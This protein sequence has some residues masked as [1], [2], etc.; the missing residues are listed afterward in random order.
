[1]KMSL[2]IIDKP[3]EIVCTLQFTMKLGDW[4][5][6]KETLESKEA[7]VELKI[8]REIRNLVSKLESTLYADCD[9]GE[10]T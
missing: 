1:M 10:R 4:K 9:D 2:A 3:E 5:Q 8:I 7:Y 6:I